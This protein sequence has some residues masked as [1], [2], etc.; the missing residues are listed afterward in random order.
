MNGGWYTNETN[1]VSDT[2]N[3]SDTSDASISFVTDDR[4]YLLLTFVMLVAYST[5]KEGCYFLFTTVKNFQ[6]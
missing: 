2:S 1:Y 3:V 4:G 5:T 6:H